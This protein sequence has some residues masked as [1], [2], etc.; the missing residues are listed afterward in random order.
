MPYWGA[1]S[2]QGYVDQALVEEEVVLLGEDGAPFFDRTR[3]VAFW[4][5][6]PIWPNNHIHVL[7]ARP[8]VSARWLAY[9][10]NDV[11]YSLYITGATRDKLTQSALKQIVLNVPNEDGQ[12]RVA[13]FLDAETAQIDRLIGKQRELIETLRERRAALVVNLVFSLSPDRVRGEPHVFGMHLAVQP[14]LRQI[15]EH[16]GLQRFWA[17]MERMEERNADLVWPMMSL[18]SSGEIVP[19]VGGRQEPKEESLPLYRVVHRD[20]LVLNPMWL[21]GG[22]VGVSKVSGAVSPEYRVFRSRGMHHPRYLHHLLRTKPYVDQYQLYTR[23]QTTFDR[24]VQQPDLDN[25]PLP[26]PPLA[27]QVEIATRI[28]AATSK[29]DRLIEKAERFIELAQ[30]R[31]A[32]LITAAVTGQIDVRRAA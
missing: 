31:R 2:I 6:E 21:I 4:I 20:D 15:P 28:D 9:A 30:E 24:R 3:P 25:M 23:S 18:K 8:E 27:E 5:N 32:A 19:R 22:A 1:N 13:D 26:V 12:Q 10:L 17:V 29:I 7:K 16:W 14:F 11:D